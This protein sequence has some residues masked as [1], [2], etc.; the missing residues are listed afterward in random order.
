MLGLLKDTQNFLSPW[1]NVV[2]SLEKLYQTVVVRNDQ[3]N[4]QPTLN[5]GAGDASFNIFATNCSLVSKCRRNS[6]NAPTFHAFFTISFFFLLLL[7]LSGV[8]DNSGTEKNQEFCLV[9]TQKNSEPVD[10]VIFKIQSDICD[11]AVSR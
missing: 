4:L 8:L 11:G 10:G 1:F 7:S 3:A 5:K 6:W 2:P 9:C